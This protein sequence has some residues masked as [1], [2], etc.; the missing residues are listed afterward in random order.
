MIIMI[1]A[2]TK[3]AE[4]RYCMDTIYWVKMPS[5][6]LMPVNPDGTSHW[7]S[8][9]MASQVKKDQAEAADEGRQYDLFGDQ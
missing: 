4:C 8:C 1:P 9:P 7:G 2:G 6:R 3:E 5:D